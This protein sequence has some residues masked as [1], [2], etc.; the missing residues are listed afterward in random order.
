MQDTGLVQ[1]SFREAFLSPRMS[2][3]IEETLLGLGKTLEIYP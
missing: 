3:A 2:L 1:R